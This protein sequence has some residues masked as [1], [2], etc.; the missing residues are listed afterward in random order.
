VLN[1]SALGTG[2][3]NLEAMEEAESYNRW[4]CGLVTVHAARI[5]IRCREIPPPPWHLCSRRCSPR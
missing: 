5:S 4:L 3:D 2:R 1:S